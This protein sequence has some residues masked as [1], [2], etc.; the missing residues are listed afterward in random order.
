MSTK[1]S[2]SHSNRH[3]LYHEVFEDNHVYL[4]LERVE[5]DASPA[6]V[7]VEIPK[8]IFESMIADYLAEQSRHLNE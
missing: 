4:E 1:S 8:D 5:F 6:R 7:T 3:H 2:I